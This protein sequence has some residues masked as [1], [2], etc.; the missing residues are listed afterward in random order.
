[1]TNPLEFGVVITDENHRITRFLE[2]P[3]WGEIFSDTINTGIYVLDPSVLRRTW[4]AARRTIFARHLSALL[5]EGKLVSGYVTKDYWT[6]IGNLQQYQ[7]ANY[8]ALAARCASRFPG[9]RTRAPESG[10]AKAAASIPS[11]HLDRTD[12]ARPQ[13]RR[14]G[15]RDV[16]DRD[17]LGNATIVAKHAH[18][19]RTV[20]WSDCYFGESSELEGCTI[21]DRNIVKDHVKVG[22]GTVIGSNCTIGAAPSCARTSSSGPTSRSAPGAVVSMS[23]IYG[24]KWPGSLFGA[25]GVSG[26]RT[27]N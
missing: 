1:V 27:S 2:K 18:V 22:E 19:E 10:W 3:S 25:V 21:A 12:R 7:Q 8:D 17:G 20:A 4:N 16:G 14:R 11:A 26:S 15:R 13:R 23:L 6:D 24:I 5:H 9:R